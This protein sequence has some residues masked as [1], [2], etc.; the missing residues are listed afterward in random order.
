MDSVSSRSAETTCIA[1]A[2]CAVLSG[3]LLDVRSEAVAL[4]FA[5]VAVLAHTRRTA[6]RRDDGA[7]ASDSLLLCDTD[8]PLAADDDATVA[9]A[10]PLDRLPEVA[11]TGSAVLLDTPL[12][13]GSA[14]FVRT[15]SRELVSAEDASPELVDVLLGLVRA[16]VDEHARESARDGDEP[17]MAARLADLIEDRHRDP[18]LDVDEIARQLHFSRRQVYRLA[19]GG[20]V[21]AMLTERRL[22]TA[23]D[24]LLERGDLS[25]S[26]VAFWSGFGNV[27]RLRVHFA[28][29]FGTTP[30]RFRLAQADEHVSG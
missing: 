17:T 22:A 26:D 30:T 6:P 24:L 23:R 25:I 21:A 19:H 29:R 20:G 12:V 5:P 10:V 11:D 9:I 28:R 7:T 1:L 2:Q 15:I 3:R 8:T 4:P 18:L 14:A 16:V 13:R 27:T